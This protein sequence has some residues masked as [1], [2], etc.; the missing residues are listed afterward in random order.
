MSCPSASP[1]ITVSEMHTARPR[2]ESDG[3]RLSRNNVKSP[4]N[5]SRLD[6]VLDIGYTFIW[7]T[8]FLDR[9]SDLLCCR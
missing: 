9:V 5:A 7:R 3:F 8:M 1:A 2:V 6:N 4:V